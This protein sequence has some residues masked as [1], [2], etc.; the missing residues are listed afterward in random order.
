MANFSN[1]RS[2]SIL[3][4]GRKP[5]VF[6]WYTLVQVKSFPQ[7]TGWKNWTVFFWRKVMCNFS[8]FQYYSLFSEFAPCENSEVI[9]S[10]RF[11]FQ[12]N[13]TFIDTRE[14]E[15]GKK[16]LNPKPKRIHVVTFLSKTLNR[17]M[18][19]QLFTVFQENR[20]FSHFFKSIRKEIFC[21]SYVTKR[22]NFG[23]ESPV[24]KEP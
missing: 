2:I 23:Q 11:I 8:E 22:N 17:F 9:R 19:S 3:T 1:H 18:N 6:P 16:K 4:L 24:I 7:R 10:S 21:F 20:S 15:I 14:T 12:L 5:K 13:S